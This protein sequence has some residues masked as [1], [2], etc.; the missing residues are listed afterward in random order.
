MIGLLLSCIHFGVRGDNTFLQWT[1]RGSLLDDDVRV[2]DP[3]TLQIIPPPKALL[4]A[5]LRMIFYSNANVFAPEIRTDYF[6]DPRP[7]FFAS[8]T[9]AVAGNYTIRL[10]YPANL[11]QGELSGWQIL[12]HVSMPSTRVPFA[13]P[14]AVCATT[15]NLRRGQ[16]FKCSELMISL[17][18]C[19][20]DWVWIPDDCRYQ[21]HSVRQLLNVR[22]TRP[23]WIA[24]L[25]DSRTRGLFLYILH[26][27][28]PT[29]DESLLVKKVWGFLD[30]KHANVRLTWRDLRGFSSGNKVLDETSAKVRVDLADLLTDND[31]FHPDYII[32]QK[33]LDFLPMFN[34]RTILLQGWEWYVITRDGVLMNS[35]VGDY[36]TAA[37]YAQLYNVSIIETDNI[38]FPMVRELCSEYPTH[39]IH[40]HTACGGEIRGLVNQI[41]ANIIVSLIL[42]EVGISASAATVDDDRIANFTFCFAGTL[43]FSPQ[44][45]FD[46]PAAKCQSRKFYHI[47]ACKW[48]GC[49]TNTFVYNRRL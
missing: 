40:M 33:G 8:V 30:Y 32:A 31:G 47:P 15:S 6:S 17:D 27:L 11:A 48:Q 41:I 21:F 20:D 29:H 44:Y 26:Q 12:I 45:S 37:L 46:L 49:S 19:V 34:A 42:K 24:F 43:E 7:S 5:G 14:V 13:Q 1:A 22:N 18:N 16:W 28:L 23:L 3:K 2:G 36:T 39:H 4:N 25:G 38:L 35:L 10:L 9:F